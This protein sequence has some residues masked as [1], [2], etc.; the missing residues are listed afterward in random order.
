MFLYAHIVPENRIIFKAP[1]FIY[2]HAATDSI[3]QLRRKHTFS[4]RL[5]GKVIS[6]IWLRW[7]VFSV[8]TVSNYLLIINQILRLMLGHSIMTTSSVTFFKRWRTTYRFSH[9]KS[10]I[11]AWQ[12]ITCH[13]RI[14]SS[15][16]LHPILNPKVLE[17]AH[18]FC[19]FELS[20]RTNLT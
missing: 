14:P 4:C 8:W 20:D 17:I 2:F 12:K 5:S 11:R 18:Y 19:G 6:A 9:R 7:S 10:W 1:R 15:G 16:H 13:F 3:F